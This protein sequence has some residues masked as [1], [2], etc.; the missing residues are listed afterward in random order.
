MRIHVLQLAYG[1]DESVAARRERVVEWV[2]AQHG[3]DL[4]VLPELW[5][6]GGFAYQGWNDLAEPIDGPTITALAQAARHL[7]TVVHAGSIV[8]S[9]PA[10][11]PREERGPTGRGRWNTSVL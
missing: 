4:V 7:G 1:D 11:R 2:R 8:E 9:V 3:A 6:P 5:A 10:D